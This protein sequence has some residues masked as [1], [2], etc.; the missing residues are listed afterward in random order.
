VTRRRP[1]FELPLDD[2]NE[3]PAFD[4]TVYQG[5]PAAFAEEVCETKLASHQVAAIEGVRD[6]Q[7]VA[8]RSCNGVGKSVTSIITA[9]WRLLCWAESVV[10]LVGPR[11]ESLRSILW[12]GIRRTVAKSKVLSELEPPGEVPGLGWRPFPDR[13]LIGTTAAEPE[14]L[15][16]LHSAHITV[17]EDE[18]SAVTS[19]MHQA[20][21][22][23]LTG[24][25]ARLLMIGNPLR[26]TGEF[27]AAFHQKKHLYYGLHTSYTDVPQGAD[28]IPGTITPAY[29]EELALDYGENSA[30]YQVR[31][32][33]NFPTDSADTVIG[34]G[35]ASE[36][37]VRFDATTRSPSDI[38]LGRLE[39]GCDPARF[40]TDQ[41]ALVLRR[42][43]V[44]FKPITWRNMDGPTV[45][46]HVL[47]EVDQAAHQNE[48]AV[49]RVD[50]IGIG[51]SVYDALVQQNHG[52]HEIVAVNV[53]ESAPTETHER[54]RDAIWFSARDFLKAGGMLPPDDRL[55]TELTAPTFSFSPRQKL[56]VEP[57]DE[58][59]KRLMGKSP[60][61]AD[62]FCLAVW[63]APE[64]PASFGTVRYHPE[65]S[66]WS[67]HG[68]SPRG[69]G[70]WQRAL[71][72]ELKK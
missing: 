25:D 45:A 9:L 53:G 35:L 30:V 55:V 65:R 72:A 51:A 7:R 1:A 38:A 26:L 48:R 70:A 13:F 20:L 5:N 57:K 37:R 60:D 43:L 14:G 50:S 56:K 58:T 29:A 68:F 10:I 27:H 22:G 41:T 40:G 4:Y 42:G 15:A 49:I 31:A 3:Q 44:A 62:A 61:L 6:H 67:A 47:A 21:L 23:N 11:G 71:A 59:K 36:A 17:V 12:R 8:W 52:R 69:G 32:L 33:G 63:S 24:E 66:N 54:V 39:A 64:Q 2:D 16:G 28:H 18:A 34:Y 19:D 46:A